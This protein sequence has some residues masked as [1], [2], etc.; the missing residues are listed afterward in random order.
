MI[1]GRRRQR[2]SACSSSRRKSP[3][4]CASQSASRERSNTSP[5]ASLAARPR[6]PTRSPRRF[7]R[8]RRG[9]GIDGL[10]RPPPSAVRVLR[11]QH[12]QPLATRRECI[13][14]WSSS[15]R[16]R[17]RTSSTY[18][19][20]RSTGIRYFRPLSG[21]WMESAGLTISPHSARRSTSA[22]RASPLRRRPPARSAA[23]DRAP[24]RS[25]ASTVVWST[26]TSPSVGRTCAMYGGTPGSGPTTRT[27]AGAA[28]RRACRA[29]RRRGAARPRSCRCPGAPCTQIDS[30]QRR[31]D[32]V[33]L[34]R[35]DG[36]D[37]VAHRADA[38]PLDLL[39][40]GTRCRWSSP[41]P[42]R[43][44]SKP[45]SSP[46]AKPKRRRRTRP[47]GSAALAR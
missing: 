33:V 29:G 27:P 35:L 23:A 31:P 39:A 7:D 14:S 36:G 44:S 11:Q 37:D 47:W 8:A 32:Q 30:A 46:S 25:S 45:V 40:A 24:G 22:I 15:A 13:S 19:L 18:R 41:R 4:T 3:A 16:P 34:V 5:A 20:S 2:S 12:R 28:D 6:R 21:T 9:L 17:R 26:S 10:R 43:S 42:R 1:G 38:G